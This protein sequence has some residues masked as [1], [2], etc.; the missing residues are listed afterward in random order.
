M[1]DESTVTPT[2]TLF[3]SAGYLAQR[4][5]VHPKTIP[6]W[7][8]SG[9]IKEDA[10]FIQTNDRVTSLF[11]EETVNMLVELIEAEREHGMLTDRE[12]KALQEENSGTMAQRLEYIRRRFAR[13][14]ARRYDE[15]MEGAA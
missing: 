9:R 15:N 2:V 11:T 10:K 4:L 5:G 1:A 7:V 14:E 6:V 12:Y 8:A 13:A 3:R